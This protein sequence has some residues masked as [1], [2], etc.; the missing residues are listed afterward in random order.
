MPFNILKIKEYRIFYDDAGK[1]WE[2]GA[3]MLINVRFRNDILA[4]RFIV[5]Y[6][7]FEVYYIFE[8]E[9]NS[10]LTTK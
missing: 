3:R 4:Q 1:A 9:I 7:I 2:L 5:S 6:C 10:L 8:V